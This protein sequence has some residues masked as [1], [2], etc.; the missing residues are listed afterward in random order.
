VVGFDANFVMLA[1][2]PGIPASVP[3]AKQR[4][5]KLLA[6]LQK[7]GERIVIPTPSLTEFLV[8]SGTAGPKYLDT[9]QK[10][11]RFK[12]ASFGVRAAVE[13]AAAIEQA[14]KK[15]NKRGGI[16][17]TLSKVNFDRQIAAVAKVEGCHS[18]Y[19]DDRD[20][21][22]FAATLGL[23]VF[24]LADLDLPPSNT[25]LLDVLDDL[26]EQ[27]PHTPTRKIVLEDLPDAPE[28]EEN[29]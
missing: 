26:E 22:K 28:K 18:L 25:P 27:K 12:I 19:S 8:H 7:A 3:R 20:L 17:G 11:S 21:G 1:L 6:D 2:R 4:V 23:R 15:G 13:V 14:I 9:I 24:T 16:K 10:A 5:E 29:K